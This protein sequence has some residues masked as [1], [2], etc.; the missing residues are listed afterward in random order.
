MAVESQNCK[1]SGLL[2]RRER[3]DKRE[4][5]GKWNEKWGTEK[6]CEEVKLGYKFNEK[7]TEKKECVV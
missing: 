4:D 3:R 7:K 2:E 1:R 6:R 5:R